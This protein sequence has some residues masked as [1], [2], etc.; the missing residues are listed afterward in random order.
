MSIYKAPTVFQQ[1]RVKTYF[2]STLS[3]ADGRQLADIGRGPFFALSRALIMH[4]I[5]V[6]EFDAQT[7]VWLVP[8][9]LLPPLVD[10]ADLLIMFL[11][12]LSLD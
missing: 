3:V 9:M 6:S 1:I 8:R 5:E 7:V 12:A 2:G 11:I 4:L 10:Q